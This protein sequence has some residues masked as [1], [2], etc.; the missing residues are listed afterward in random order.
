MQ[1]LGFSAQA[2]DVTT[3]EMRAYAAGLSA[4]YELLD[5]AIGNAFID[6]ADEATISSLIL[7][8]CPSWTML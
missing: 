8:I 7:W 6:T 2:G 4:V 3:A 5:K 1:R